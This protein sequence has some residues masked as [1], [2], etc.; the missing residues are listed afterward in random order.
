MIVNIGSNF[1]AFSQAVLEKRPILNIKIMGEESG[2]ICFEGNEYTNK[3]ITIGRG[4]S[5]DLRL[6]DN[7]LSKIHATVFYNSNGWNLV[8]GDMV[9]KSTNGTWL[10]LSEDFEMY[11]NMIFKAN[12]AVFQVVS[13]TNSSY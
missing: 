2:S 13:V 1:L 10:Y 4:I 9:K 3:H 11:T 6:D 5:C 12:Q 8:D 7:L